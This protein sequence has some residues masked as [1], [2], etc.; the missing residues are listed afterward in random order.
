MMHKTLPEGSYAEG[1]G[2]Q[3]V[4]LPYLSDSVRMLI[5]LPAEGKF[6]AIASGLSDDFVQQML[7]AMKQNSVTLT[8]PRFTFES[9]NQLKAPLQALGMIS[10]FGDADFSGIDGTRSLFISEVYHKAFIAVDEK[11]TEAAAATAVVMRKVAVMENKT[12]T[13]DRPF[14][15][16][17]YD[18][19][20]GEILFLGHLKD[21]TP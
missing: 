14:I 5:L 2:Y 21:P 15:F 13:L 16:L 6:D 11:G 18:K 1:D 9:E 17:I 4:E 19:P 12:V 7:S 3:A 20:T 10:A 8:M